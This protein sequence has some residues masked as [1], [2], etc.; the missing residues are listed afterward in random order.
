MKRAK[1]FMYDR[2]AGLLTEDENGFTFAYDTAYMEQEGIEAISLTMPLREAPYKDK[3][4]FPFFDGLI[5]E[6]WLLGIAERSWKIN[7]RDR[8][9]LLLACCKDCIGAVSVV[10]YEEDNNP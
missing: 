6:G 3:V 1:I 8:M 2:Y 10:P 9:S 5:P 7:Q 4:L